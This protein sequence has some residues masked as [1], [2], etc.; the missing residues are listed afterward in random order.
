[1]DEPVYMKPTPGRGYGRFLQARY[2][3]PFDPSTG[4]GAIA[5][6]GIAV[7]ALTGQVLSVALFL[8]IAGLGWRFVRRPPQPSLDVTLH[9]FFTY[10]A[11]WLSF[12]GLAVLLVAVMAMAPDMIRP[13]LVHRVGLPP[14]L[15]AKAGIAHPDREL[16][17]VLVDIL[18]PALLGLWLHAA[19]WLPYRF[20]AGYIMDRYYAAASGQPSAGHRVRGVAALVPAS[21]ALVVVFVVMFDVFMPWSGVGPGRGK[22]VAVY[23]AAGL[24][25]LII[26]LFLACYVCTGLIACVNRVFEPGEAALRRRLGR[27]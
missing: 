3:H 19:R 1:M 16:F 20:D 4:F 25:V 26:R 13:Y 9:T 18:V 14:L 6:L 21:M 10:P 22:G 8:L 24:F 27:P 11:Y 5:I 15:L 23:S 2:P 7:L 12:T 17:W